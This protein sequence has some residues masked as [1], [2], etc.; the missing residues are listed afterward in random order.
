[1]ELNTR[2]ANFLAKLKKMG[3]NARQLYDDC[4]D[5]DESWSEEFNGSNGENSL[6]ILEGNAEINGDSNSGQPVLNID[7]NAGFR[8]GDSIIIDKGGS[9]EETAEIET[10]GSTSI[11]L[12]TNLIYTHTAADADGVRTMGPLYLLGLSVRAI[13]QMCNRF[14]GQYAVFWEGGTPTVREYGKIARRVAS[15]E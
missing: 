4:K 3:D 11:T 1:M 13:Q 6:S 9:R 12:T 2:Q 8:A 7:L 10:V 15:N 14:G 5:I